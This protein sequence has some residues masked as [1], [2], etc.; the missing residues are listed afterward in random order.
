MIPA[1]GLQD[2]FRGSVIRR[3][4]LLLGE[5]AGVVCMRRSG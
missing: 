3:M 5:G 1:T 2:P 4:V